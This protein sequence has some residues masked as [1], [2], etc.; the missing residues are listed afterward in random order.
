[1]TDKKI[2]AFFCGPPKDHK[3]DD[4]GP[5]LYG[6]DSVETTTDKTK[7]GKGYSWGSTSCSV[8]G[9]TS[10]DLSLWRDAF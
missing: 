5:F 1:M 6:G 3:C 9:M 7:A 8:C 4:N 2:T 10:M